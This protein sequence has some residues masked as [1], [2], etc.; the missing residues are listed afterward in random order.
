M[1]TPED[2]ERKSRKLGNVIAINGHV[3]RVLTI[4]ALVISG[5]VVFSTESLQADRKVF[6]GTVLGVCALALQVV[7][8]VA[9]RDEAT[10]VLFTTLS[11]FLSGLALGLGVV[12]A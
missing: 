11:A 8:C 9:A 12:Y 3:S 5:A 4:L 1:S 7:L 2:A 6:F 10:L